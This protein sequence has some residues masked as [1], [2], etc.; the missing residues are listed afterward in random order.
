M[1]TDEEQVYRGNPRIIGNQGR[2]KKT[3]ED[4]KL[5]H[6]PEKY[7]VHTSI[8]HRVEKVE[9]GLCSSLDYLWPMM[10]MS[11]RAVGNKLIL[12]SFHV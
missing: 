11:G 9:E 10:M 5:E 7:R 3:G 12:K 4:I 1:T 6:L 8:S 2:R